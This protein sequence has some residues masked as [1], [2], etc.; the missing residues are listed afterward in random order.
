MRNKEIAHPRDGSLPGS[1]S[2]ARL[3]RGAS[4]TSAFVPR[5]E[6]SGSRRRGKHSRARRKCG[7]SQDW[8]LNRG[9]HGFRRVD[10]TGELL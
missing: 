5:R 7:S 6:H 4:S 3:W 8:S 9:K 10:N 2:R 1:A